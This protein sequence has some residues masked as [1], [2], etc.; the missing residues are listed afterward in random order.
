MARCSATEPRTTSR[1]TM[2]GKS[3]FSALTG[4]FSLN[5]RGNYSRFIPRDGANGLMRDTW[6]GIGL[7]LAEAAQKIGN[8]AN[9][10]AKEK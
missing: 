3:I 5:R 4:L 6:S 2:S 8:E 9:E 7:R 10:K 1:R